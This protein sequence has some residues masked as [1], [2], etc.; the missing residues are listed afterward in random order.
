MTWASLLASL[1]LMGTLMANGAGNANAAAQTKMVLVVLSGQ[2][3]CGAAGITLGLSV[4]WSTKK[5]FLLRLFA[6]LLAAGVLLA[7][8]RVYAFA[9]ML[10]G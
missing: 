3:L 6:G 8:G 9:S 2:I 1:S 5:I 4:C 10:P 7:F